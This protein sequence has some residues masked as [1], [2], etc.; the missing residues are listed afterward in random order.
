MT[1]CFV[2]C[3]EWCFPD[4]DMTVCPARAERF[5][6][7]LDEC[8]QKIKHIVCRCSIGDLTDDEIEFLECENYDPDFVIVRR[9]EDIAV[10]TGAE[11]IEHLRLL[12]QFELM[13]E[14]SK[15]PDSLPD[16]IR[17]RFRQMVTLQ[18]LAKELI[19]ARQVV[20]KI[21]V[22]QQA[23]IDN[24][25]TSEM[26]RNSISQPISVIPAPKPVPQPTKKRHCPQPNSTRSKK[27]SKYESI[28]DALIEQNSEAVVEG[29]KKRITVKEIVSEIK[30][31]GIFKDMQM[32]T[33]T[34]I[35]KGVTRTSAWKHRKKTVS[36]AQQQARPLGKTYSER[37]RNDKHRGKSAINMN[38]YVDV[39]NDGGRDSN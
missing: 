35:A 12:S 6:C 17:P 11:R 24:L 38:S 22:V 37:R 18:F 28:V 30:K 21:G 8:P 10:H 15:V 4:C 32:P 29:E 5:S 33:D 27:E 9:A 26:V 20:P 16:H 36:E 2:D 25:A 23:V 13:Y 7:A 19:E 31:M 34:S 14:R 1:E 3:S 39:N